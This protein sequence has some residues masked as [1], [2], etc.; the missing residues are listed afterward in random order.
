MMAKPDAFENRVAK[1]DGNIEDGEI[2][3]ETVVLIT[4]AGKIQSKK[5]GSYHIAAPAPQPARE[6]KIRRCRAAP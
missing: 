2:G 3:R 5:M 1:L 4:D 6:R